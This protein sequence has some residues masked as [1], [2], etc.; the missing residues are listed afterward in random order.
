M[1]RLSATLRGW[2][3]AKGREGV[4][5]YC[6]GCKG[7]HAVTTG[8]AGRPGVWEWNGALNAPTFSPSILIMSGCNRPGS[9]ALGASC[10]CA[11]NAERVAQGKPPSHFKCGTCHS[12]VRGGMIEFLADCTHDLAGQTVPLPSW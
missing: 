8:P 6:P 11:Y 4:T 1:G 3:D 5:F 10:W 9:S 2:R 7:A 12:F